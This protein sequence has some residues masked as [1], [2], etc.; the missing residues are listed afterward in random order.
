MS[1]GV[2]LVPLENTGEGLQMGPNLAAGERC[3]N[4]GT[5]EGEQQ[6]CSLCGCCGG[7][8]A[9]ALP[10]CSTCEMHQASSAWSPWKILPGACVESIDGCRDGCL[11]AQPEMLVCCVHEVT[12]S[13]PSLGLGARK[14]KARD[15]CAFLTL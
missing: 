7:Q 5:R 3:R 2:D 4:A 14:R 6:S 11:A 13:S 9:A 8:E 15:G 1:Q 10:S 12:R